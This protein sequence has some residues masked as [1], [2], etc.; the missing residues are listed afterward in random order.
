MP[1]S[2]EGLHQCVDWKAEPDSSPGSGLL[3]RPS[4]LLKNGSING[5]QRLSAFGVGAGG[6]VSESFRLG[7]GLERGENKKKQ[8]LSK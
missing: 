6:V 8:M 2:G 3:P 1:R 4:D 7:L 5:L